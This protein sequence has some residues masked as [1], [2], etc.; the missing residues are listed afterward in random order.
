MSHTLLL[1]TTTP[2]G[3]EKEG[4]S[5]STVKDL[6]AKTFTDCHDLK[7]QTRSVHGDKYFTAWEWVITCKHALGPDGKPL[8]K[9][10]ARPKKATGC[11]QMWWNDNDKIVKNHEYMQARDE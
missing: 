2:T 1:L 7:I 10:E 9:E 5:H 4:L 6:F 11:T 3:I 8:R